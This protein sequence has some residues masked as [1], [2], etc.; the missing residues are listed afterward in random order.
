MRLKDPCTGILLAAV[1]VS[2]WIRIRIVIFAWI[3][4]RIRK[5]QMQIR[6][7]DYISHEKWVNSYEKR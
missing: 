4:I 6:N 7:T 1:D 3:Q 5:N 2:S